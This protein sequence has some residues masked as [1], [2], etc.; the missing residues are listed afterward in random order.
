MMV[1]L[2]FQSAFQGGFVTDL[3]LQEV[4]NLS[5]KE[6]SKFLEEEA[7]TMFGHGR[8]KKH[9]GDV[10]NDLSS[11][12]ESATLKDRLKSSFT[13]LLSFFLRHSRKLCRVPIRRKA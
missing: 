2:V 3:T 6:L 11:F 9:A 4:N 8:P 5:A 12:L 10:D 1:E 7:H 13:C